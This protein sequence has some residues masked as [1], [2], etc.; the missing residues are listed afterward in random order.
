MPVSKQGA[1]Y[2]LRTMKP[3]NEGNPKNNSLTLLYNSKTECT[4]PILYLTSEIK[5]GQSLYKFRGLN[6]FP[7]AWLLFGGF[8]VLQL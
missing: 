6:S 2:I 3:P 1:S 7:Q 4:F 5:K 8:T